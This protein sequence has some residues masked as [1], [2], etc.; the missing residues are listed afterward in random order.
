MKHGAGIV[1]TRSITYYLVC[2]LVAIIQIEKR[3]TRR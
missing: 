1:A 2:T 3:K